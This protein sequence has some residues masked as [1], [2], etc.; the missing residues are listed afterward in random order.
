MPVILFLDKTALHSS[1]P[2]AINA[3]ALNI[4]A[5]TI[6]AKKA[7]AAEAGWL[8]QGGPT[9]PFCNPQPYEEYNGQYE[10][11]ER[12]SDD[13]GQPYEQYDSERYE[14]DSGPLQYEVPA[15][16]LA[17]QPPPQPSKRTHP[18]EQQKYFNAENFSIYGIH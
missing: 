10:S 1:T 15:L 16:T 5:R 4:R 8:I 3:A 17:P 6:G 13:E 11:I 2:D 9:L 18:H 12:N 7:T 14:E